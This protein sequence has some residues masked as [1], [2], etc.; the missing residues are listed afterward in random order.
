MRNVLHAGTSFGRQYAP[1]DLVGP[2]R[3]FV[4]RE[5]A[6][7]MAGQRWT[8]T[9][10]WDFE[11]RRPALT[12]KPSDLFGVILLQAAIEVD[13]GHGLRRCQACRR[14]FRPRHRADQATCSDTCRTRVYRARQG[15]AR[16]LHAQGKGVREIAA[17]L[18]SDLK[19]VRKWIGREKD[20][21]K[22][23]GS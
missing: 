13:R 11:R 12:A 6:A 15:Q 10:A 3:H 18:E 19:T 8:T 4:Q 1:G 20:K 5:L 21:G 16:Q 2:A 7:L 14:W 9:L 23:K 22:G 17:E